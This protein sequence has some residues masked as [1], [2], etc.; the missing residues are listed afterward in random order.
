MSKR[1]YYDVLGVGRN[2]DDKEIK[3][4]YRKLAMA[5]HPDR[6]PDD[7][8]AAER[9][10]EASEAYEVLK[11]SQKRA[12]YDRL[13]HAAFDQQAGGG[14]GGGGFGGGGFGGG[15]SDIFDQMF[16]EFS[17]GRGGNSTRSGSDLRY[18]MD[19]TLEEA[20]SGLQKDIKVTVAA[21]CESC[22]GTGAAKGSKAESCG[23]CGG[24]G[25]VRQQQGFFTL[26][27][28]CP[29]CQGQGEMISDPCRS[30]G[31]EGRVNKAQTLAVN[32]P[33]G[34]DTGT[35]IRL[36]GKGEAGIRGAQAGDL[37]IFVN[38]RPHNIF[39]RDGSNLM[40]S[41]PLPMATAALG[42][43]IDV[44]TISGKMARLTIDAGTQSG[45]KFRM[46]GKGMP[47]LRGHDFGDQIVE[48]QVET[49]T[50]LTDK[51]KELLEEFQAAGDVSPKAKSWYNRVKDLFDAS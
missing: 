15:F 45:R 22:V 19:I 14:F 40:T 47:A 5:N 36:S 16:N 12:A 31:G 8:A 18:D 42:G 23:T 17:G 37:Y 7:E 28:T 34:V 39:V 25:K 3:S 24:V 1:D 26:E 33:K 10:R 27:R 20:F 41:V 30:C 9:F 13:G 32:I 2:A 49:P 11:D 35:R 46:R 51:Q 48:I 29:S 43:T 44:P 50:D 6:N 4:A 38:V 21:S